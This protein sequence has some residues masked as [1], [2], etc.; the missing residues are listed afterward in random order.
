MANE[1]PKVAVFVLFM[2]G[3]FALSL[4]GDLATAVYAQQGQA[5][6]TVTRVV[7]GDTSR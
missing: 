1:A 7:D 6:A 4:S 3:A 2:V 5:T